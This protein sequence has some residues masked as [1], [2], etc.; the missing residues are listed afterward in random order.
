VTTVEAVGKTLEE[1]RTQAAA[2]L[3]VDQGLLEVEIIEEPRRLLGIIGP[4][5]YRIRATVAQPTATPQTTN[6]H[7]EGTDMVT[8]SASASSVDLPTRAAETVTA[9]LEHMGLDARGEVR[10]AN[11]EEVT[12]E[13][14]GQDVGHVIGRHGATLDAMQLL[15][16][17]IVNKDNQCR[18]VRVILDAEGYRDRRRQMLERMAHTHA[19]KAK[20][21]GKEVVIPDLKPYERR[22]IHLALKD[23]P[24]VETYSEGEG[25][26]RHIVISPRG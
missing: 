15:V 5:E 3:G 14:E 24:D 16:A 9:L 13:I 6:D 12:V 4:G 25:E 1:A 7:I 10:E 2:Q 18:P 11:E 19:A 21:A 26:D 23:D 17:V 20:Q 8:D 22:I